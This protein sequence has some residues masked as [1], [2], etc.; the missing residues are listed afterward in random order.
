MKSEGTP[1]RNDLL[2]AK[3]PINFQSNIQPAPQQSQ[4]SHYD[5][6]PATLMHPYAHLPSAPQTHSSVRG[7]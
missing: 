2:A 7:Y 5:L 1:S 6:R 3:Q 4:L